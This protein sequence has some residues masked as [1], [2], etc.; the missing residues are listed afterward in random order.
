MGKNKNSIAT[1]L[2][3]SKSLKKKRKTSLLKNI[4]KKVIQE[5]KYSCPIVGIG[6]SAGGLEAFIQ[7]LSKIPK[8]TGLAFILVQHLEPSH[9]SLAANIIAK[10][11]RLPIFEAQNSMK[12]KPNQ[13]YIIPPNYDMQIINGSLQLSPRSD[14]TGLHL[15]IDLFFQSL[16]LAEGRKAIGIVL[17]GTGTDGTQGLRAIKT[18]GG[19]TFA[20]LP[21][22]AKFDGMPQNAINAGVADF[23]L[24]PTNIAKELI[25]LATHPYVLT[26]TPD[27]IGTELDNSNEALQRI[28]AL[29]RAHTNVDF[30]N[31]KYATLNR[32]IQRRMLVQ[33]TKT[34]QSYAD[35]LSIHS[36][37]IKF[38]FND[39]LIN[40][41]E[42]FRDPDSFAEIT[43]TVFPQLVKNRDLQKPIR[44]WVPG[45]SSGE[46]VYSIAIALIEFLNQT[47]ARIPIQI[48]A[49]DISEQSIQKA[50][51]GQYPE[52]IAQHVS[53]QRL[54]LFFEKT[55]HGYKIRK[56]V[57][58]ICLF[59][60]HDMTYDPPFAKLD[61]ISCR[62]VLIYFANDLQKRVIPIFH[63]ALQPQGFL[64]LGRAETPG[65]YSKLF[66]L[67]NKTHK[68][69]A[70]SNVPTPLK[71]IFPANVYTPESQTSTKGEFP[72]P[73]P[74][75]DLQKDVD[76]IILSRYAPPSVIVNAE[77]EILQFRGRIVPF[78]E[79]PKTGHPSN[80]LFKMAQPELIAGLRKLIN[81]VK[82]ENK[83]AKRDKLHFQ[84][85]G[86]EKIVTIEACPINSLA[87]PKERTYLI[88][89]KELADSVSLLNHGS[90]KQDLR[91][92]QITELLHELSEVRDTQAIL[93]EQHE[94]TQEE[95]TSSNE[96][97]QSTNEELQS[98]NEELETAKEE[99]QSTNEELVTVNDELQVRNHDLT[100]IGSDL[101]NLLAS[102]EIPI[103]MVGND[104][105]IRRFTPRAELA[106][107][108]ISTDIG[109]PI[110]DIKS[111]FNLDLDA[112][113]SEVTK[114]LVS[115]VIEVQDHVGAWR[116]LQIRPYQTT[117][118]KIDGVVIA[119]IDIEELKQREKISREAMEYALSI[120]DTVLFPLVILDR[121]YQFK[122]V[123]KAFS[124]HFL[125][126]DLLGKNLFTALNITE[127]DQQ[128]LIDRLSQTINT[129]TAFTDFEIECEFPG[130]GRLNILL[131]G[132]K[133]M[134]MGITD[135]AI[136]LSL[137]DVTEQ[138]RIE[139]ELQLWLIR[140]QAARNDAEK[141][142]RAKDIFL[143]TLSHELRTPLS[144]ILTWA[145]LIRT[146]KVDFENAKKGA[147]IIEQSAKTQSQLIDD[148]LDIS[149][150]IAGKLELNLKEVYLC[151]VIQ[152][153]IESVRPMAERKSIQIEALLT[154]ET[155]IIHGDPVRLQQIIW[156][157]LTNAI[158]FS[159]KGSSIEVQ[160][161]FR[162]TPT[163]N[164]AEIKVIDHGTGIN[165][166]F[167]PH[168]FSRF[169]Q[170][171]SAS[172]RVHGGLGL[173]LSI[174][175]N[176]VQLHGGTVRVENAKEGTGAIFTVTLPLASLTKPKIIQDDTSIHLQPPPKQKIEPDDFEISNDPSLEGLRI[177]FVDDDESTRDAIS[178][179]LKTLGA[180][181]RSADSAKAAL[182]ILHQFV[183]HILVSDIAMPN[184][185]GYTLIGK[186]RELSPEQGSDIPAV[187]LTA[188]AS[189]EDAK[190]ALAA[191]F[192]AHLAKPVEDSELAVV[193]LR[194]VK[195]RHNK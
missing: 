145:Y 119:L 91:N 31:Y 125:A 44:I 11:I 47:G 183:P 5:I 66:T 103:L 43:S 146:G 142:N 137:V 176:L 126:K 26:P 128:I 165:P 171:D 61:L 116:R 92:I 64:W 153:A 83:P 170:A 136:L 42:F 195:Q 106:F 190:H 88:L 164:F 175:Q 71:F 161:E 49:T 186:I 40:V 102:T 1:Q 53:E 13:V 104:K 63:Y 149:R 115:K 138:R 155:G 84:V 55:A 144:S 65:E 20:Q 19:L 141:A 54:R 182:N 117:D 123:N 34:L 135:E 132:R 185:D 73:Q 46:E 108:L 177:L 147:A 8:D 6:A 95:L 56:A 48:F 99:L 67:V 3:Q 166:E 120:T 16:A 70:K 52:S 151:T 179:Y 25:R 160:L 191:G 37:E 4:P 158:K 181:V 143:A 90:K 82:K 129:N 188:F 114:T 173:G 107:N 24:T 30:T 93:I 89:F 78:L 72:H 180:E 97:L 194:L 118:N 159:P 133:M 15:T 28:F 41:T 50:R 69:Y 21:N 87:S 68:I 184:E 178:L 111:N 85:D 77:M 101:N 152:T 81:F 121:N 58:D 36:E 110:S 134:S 62:N 122:S 60:T 157:L 45:C 59:S 187:A 18:E 38:L 124:K 12:I 96:E 174:V 154:P 113:I 98:T 79:P 156:N 112:L 109:R 80:N 163:E 76:K 27:K 150:I 86:K 51:L 14:E 7:L 10:S 140:E 169:S 168:V 22:S 32:R 193:L 105:C 189:A 9:P 162:D 94:S 127:K 139:K 29:L 33:K 130:L 74:L 131:S 39:I 23:I 192:Q 2:L 17:S 148:L 100:T 75:S 57:R 35:Y 167:L 172:T